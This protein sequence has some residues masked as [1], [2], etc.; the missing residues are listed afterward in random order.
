MKINRR[1]DELIKAAQ[2]PMLEKILASFVSE[3]T[4]A[5]RQQ[6]SQDLEVSY[7][8]MI[9]VTLGDYN[10][11]Q[12]LPTLV[13]V[14]SIEEW[15]GHGMITIQKDLVYS[16]IELLLGGGAIS[17]TL[18]VEGRLFTKIEK[19]I[20]EGISS[21][22]LQSLQKAFAVIANIRFTIQKIENNPNYAL[23]YNSDEIVILQKIKITSGQRFGDIDLVLPYNM[24]RSIKSLLVKQFSNSLSPQNK[25]W[26]EH[27]SN[28][29]ENADVTMT[30]EVRNI[31]MT[32]ND[33]KK[34]KI[35]DTIIT[36]N[37]IADEV[38]ICVNGIVI[39]KGKLGKIGDKLAIQLHS[40]DDINA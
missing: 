6:L 4:D 2:L 40:N 22:I 26:Y 17:P 1:K 23:P 12:S 10:E 18:K 21:T 9:P 19:S 11:G 8:K 29:M 39:N 38:N 27:F 16:M 34:A 3:V 24:L 30:V 32:L 5:L 15:N 20:L 36:D 31:K 37:L 14:F 13:C 7:D 25:L 35:G 28:I 33:I